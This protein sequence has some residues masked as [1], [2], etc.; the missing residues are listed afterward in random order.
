MKLYV[1]FS[2]VG[3]LLS[4]K[5][6]DD[7]SEFPLDE[8]IYVYP[9]RTKLNADGKDTTVVVARLPKDAGLVDVSFSTSAGSFIYSGE[10]SDKQYARRV[11]GNYRYAQ[12]ILQSDTAPRDSVYVTAEVT[13]V[14][15]RT[16]LSFGK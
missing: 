8:Q 3:L 9:Y 2:F 10:K 6:P 12:T 1:Y 13:Q 5:S 4:C 7:P 11:I 15:N 16:R 14:R